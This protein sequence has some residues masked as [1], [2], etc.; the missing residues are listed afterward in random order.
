MN[1]MRMA[2]PR[3]PMYRPTETS[4]V[5]NLTDECL[6][7]VS[8]PQFEMS[9]PSPM[10]GSCGEYLDNVTPPQLC[11]TAD[12][13][14]SEKDSNNCSGSVQQRVVHDFSQLSACDYDLLPAG[15]CRDPD[16]YSM[17]DQKFDKCSTEKVTAVQKLPP[18]LRV[19]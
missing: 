5:N 10:S 18:K 17:P 9:M 14:V 1:A 7:D 16:Q 19:H 6:A 13:S 15:N 2:Q 3:R 11:T 4:I 8:A 12:S